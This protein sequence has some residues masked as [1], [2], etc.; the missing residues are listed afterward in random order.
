V[1]LRLF[2]TPVRRKLNPADEAA[3]Y[4]ARHH[5]VRCS[6]GNP[7]HVYEW[8]EGPRTALILHGWGSHAARFTALVGALT[9][10][11]WRVLA[12]DAP[13]HGESPGSTSS[14]PQFMAALDAVME[15]LGPVQALVGHSMGSLAIA[16]RLSDSRSP[17]PATL[18]QAVLISMPSGVP[19]LADSFRQLFGIGES[20]AAH[21]RRL[22]ERR[23]GAVPE[24]FLALAP[25]TR[26]ELPVLLVH[27]EADDVVPF[28]HSRQLLARLPGAKLLATHGLGHSWLLR[29]PATIS[30]IAQFMDEPRIAP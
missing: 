29:D 13:G 18:T 30:A 17:P 16:M 10:R 19:F 9:E 21:G 12:P 8:G 2:L 15:Q 27:D 14:L 20:T 28:E 7:I 26:I 5:F 22:F 6:N 23:F 4:S 1:A 24:A 11:G 3:M 25:G